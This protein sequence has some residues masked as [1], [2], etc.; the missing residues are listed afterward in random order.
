M[1]ISLITLIKPA[2]S[3]ILQGQR[4][5]GIGRTRMENLTVIAQGRLFNG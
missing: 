5:T 1:V 3:Q 2:I 4:D